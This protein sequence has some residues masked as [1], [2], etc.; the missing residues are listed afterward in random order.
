MA[1]QLQRSGIATPVVVLIDTAYPAGSRQNESRLEKIRRYR[2]L[3]RRVANGGGLSHFLERVKYG[4]ARVAHRTS[5][6]V[7]IPL[8]NSASD[9]ATL[10]GLAS[11]SY[12][13]K[14]YHGRV[15]LFRAESQR[16]FLTGGPDLGWS[17]VLSNLVVEE[18]PG[19]HGTINIGNNLKILTR[20]IRQCLQ[21]P[22]NNGHP[23][24]SP[25][26]YPPRFAPDLR[27]HIDQA[28]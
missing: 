27:K 22:L 26:H 23:P 4:V 3:G 10:Q 2:H 1:R 8:P 5:L 9:V 16:E 15:H 21:Y 20:K 7:G 12:R 14:S 6:T 19:D 17:G 13:L 28:Q 18:V 24:E 25:L 11:E